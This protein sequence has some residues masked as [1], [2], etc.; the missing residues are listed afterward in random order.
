MPIINIPPQ[1]GKRGKIPKQQVELEALDLGG[2]VVV[3]QT[4]VVSGKKQN[5]GTEVVRDEQGRVKK[6]KQGRPITRPAP[7]LLRGIKKRAEVE[8]QDPVLLSPETYNLDLTTID[9]SAADKDRMYEE[10]RNRKG[11]DGQPLWKTRQE[12][13]RALEMARKR[14]PFTTGKQAPIPP[15]LGPRLLQDVDV[16]RIQKKIEEDEASIKQ[17]KRELEILEKKKGADKGQ[18]AQK[19]NEISQLQDFRDAK[20]EAIDLGTPIFSGTK[21]ERAIQ[22]EEYRSSRP[23]A[24]LPSNLIPS[25]FQIQNI[26]DKPFVKFKGDKNQIPTGNP[27][28]QDR[29]EQAAFGDPKTVGFPPRALRDEDGKIIRTGKGTAFVKVP[30]IKAGKARMSPLA[31]KSADEITTQLEKSGLVLTQKGKEKFQEALS[32]LPLYR[33]TQKKDFQQSTIGGEKQLKKQIED[34]R[35]TPTQDQE[36]AAKLRKIKADAQK[37]VLE[38]SIEGPEGLVP[39]TVDPAELKRARRGSM[40]KAEADKAFGQKAL[41]AITKKLEELSRAPEDVERLGEEKAGFIPF[42]SPKAMKGKFE[43]SIATQMV[44]KGKKK[45]EINAPTS[46]ETDSSVGRFSFIKTP[47]VKRQKRTEQVVPSKERALPSVNI[48]GPSSSRVQ[49]PIYSKLTKDEIDFID[50]QTGAKKPRDPDRDLWQEAER[51]KALKVE[52]AKRSKQEAAKATKRTKF[53]VNLGKFP[54]QIVDE[55]KVT[56]RKVR[57]K[58]RAEQFKIDQLRPAKGITISDPDK[59]KREKELAEENFQ[60]AIAGAPLLD[61]NF[62]PIKEKK[63]TKRKRRR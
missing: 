4:L 21:A 36:T 50:K 32:K 39:V 31:T 48:T 14:D 2:E 15:G 8:G 62:K 44:G 51:E 5:L 35:K 63:K 22:L 45:K 30:E 1:M 41:S 29:L 34:I 57:G 47:G 42:K 13:D 25:G 17:K 37:D 60:R 46:I 59:E 3:G 58:G 10:V 43:P 6:D 52:E 49:S 19:K 24:E 18:I 56:T 27:A 26:A 7:I 53:L 38:I 61:E 12:F 9:M 28:V 55:N 20:K 54:K 33:Q 16:S 11:K 23:E 40:T